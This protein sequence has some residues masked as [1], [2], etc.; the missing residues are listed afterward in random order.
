MGSC[1]VGIGILFLLIP[2]WLVLAF[3]GYSKVEIFQ[4]L[5]YWACVLLIGAVH[6]LSK[7]EAEATKEAKAL[8]EGLA[9]ARD[10]IRDMQADLRALQSLLRSAVSLPPSPP[11]HRE[12][13]GPWDRQ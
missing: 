4:N 5:V 6:A 8:R 12:R 3:L 13:L 1:A 7:R 10:E 11:A 2:G 9:G